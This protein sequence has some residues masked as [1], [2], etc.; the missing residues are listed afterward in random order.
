MNYE[1]ANATQDQL[2]AWA[3]TAAVAYFDQ[4]ESDAWEAEQR[5]VRWA[6]AGGYKAGLSRPAY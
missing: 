5:Q 4:L 6:E 3:E 2:D 1:Y